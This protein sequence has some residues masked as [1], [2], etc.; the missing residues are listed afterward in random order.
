MSSV[1]VDILKELLF[2]N[3]DRRANPVLDGPMRPN[4]ALEECP[5]L[6]DA[7]AEP[8]DVAVATDGSVY[9][10]AGRGVYRFDDADFSNP[11]IVAEFDGLAT[12][13]A[14]HPAGGVAVCVAGQGIALI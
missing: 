14:A 12:G 3:R 5:V 11:T 1:V 10:T 13:V 2:R 8:D 9:V 6:S 7:I 4:S